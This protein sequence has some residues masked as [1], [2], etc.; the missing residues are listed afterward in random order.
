LHGRYYIGRRIHMPKRKGDS[1]FTPL[2]AKFTNDYPTTKENFE[3]AKSEVIATIEKAI[4]TS[5]SPDNFAKYQA[6]L[7][8]AAQIKTWPRLLQLVWN[9][10]QA[11]SGNKV[12][13]G[14]K[15]R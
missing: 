2:T 5:K 11:W 12:L 8:D 1:I 10:D 6:M 7:T 15:I 4:E 3:E 14:T 13:S 9:E